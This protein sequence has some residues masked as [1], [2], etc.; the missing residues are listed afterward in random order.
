[1]TNT[2]CIESYHTFLLSNLARLKCD[3]IIIAG[4]KIPAIMLFAVVD[5][6]WSI[7]IKAYT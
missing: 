3:R 4:I 1:M 2:L 7:T 5:P 6:Y